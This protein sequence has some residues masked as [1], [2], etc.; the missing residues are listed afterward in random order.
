MRHGDH[1]GIGAVGLF[2]E[3]SRHLADVAE[4]VIPVLYDLFDLFPDV[5]ILGL[6]V[7]FSAA[8]LGLRGRAQLLARLPF[9]P[10][11]IP[12]DFDTVFFRALPPLFCEYRAGDAGDGCSAERKARPGKRRFSGECHQLF[13]LLLFLGDMLCDKLIFLHE[14]SSAVLSVYNAL[15]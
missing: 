4:R 5:L 10:A 15:V 2:P 1:R 13:S 14:V 11:L 8:G 7:H 3:R 12:L 6:P 9:A